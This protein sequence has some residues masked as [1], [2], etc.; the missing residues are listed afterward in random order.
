MNRSNKVHKILPWI[1]MV[2]ALIATAL[3]TLSL[4]R[5]PE[6]VELSA[7]A[8]YLTTTNLLDRPAAE[9]IERMILDAEA[10]GICIVVVD[11]HRTEEEQQKIIERAKEKGEEKY[12]AAVGESEHHTGK[13]VDLGGC[14]MTDGVRDDNAERLELRKPFEELPEYA[15]LQ[16]HAAEY[17][18]RQT[19]TKENEDRTGMP[20]EA[21]HWYYT[22]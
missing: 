3:T 19:Y 7:R 14:P 18:Y 20:A 12:A 8:N 17:G 16:E 10:D 5:E 22:K 9:A 6:L 2:I 1:V 4:E 21:W 13:A 11:G 15:W